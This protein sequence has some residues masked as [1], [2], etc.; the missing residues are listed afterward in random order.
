M[1]GNPRPYLTESESARR[2]KFLYGGE[3]E[4]VHLSVPLNPGIKRL[5]WYFNGRVL[6][7]GDP[8]SNSLQVAV[9]SETEGFYLC[10]SVSEDG[11]L[12]LLLVRVVRLRKNTTAHFA[13]K[14]TPCRCCVVTVT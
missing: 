1:T 7:S 13:P 11:H 4:L 6:E 3:R 9:T 2:F 12:K 8:L 14:S 5:L 10:F